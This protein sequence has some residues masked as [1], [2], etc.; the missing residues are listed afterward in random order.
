MIY[1]I[2]D[3]ASWQKSL[4]DGLYRPAAFSSDGFIHCS[5]FSQVIDVANRFY[6]SQKCLILLA[7][8]NSLVKSKIVEENSEGGNELFPHLYGP[9]EV[10]SVYAIADL[11]PNE[12]GVFIFPNYWLVQKV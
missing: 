4:E 7:I 11:N 12:D 8:N 3:K 1:H 10:N 5:K 9:L 6:S 2:T